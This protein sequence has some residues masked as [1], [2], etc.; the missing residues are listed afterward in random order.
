M[1]SSPSTVASSREVFRFRV[2][3]MDCASCSGKIETAVCRIPG[4][5]G[6]KVSFAASTLTVEADPALVSAG[7]IE[8][9]VSALGFQLTGVARGGVPDGS[10]AE[11]RAAGA[12]LGDVP[13]W[14]TGKARITAAAGMLVAA[15]Y[16]LSLVMPRTVPPGSS[17]PQPPSRPFRSRVGLWQR[18]LPAPRS[19]SKC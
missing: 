3:G 9:T 18:L 10:G 13:W 11:S 16:G 1:T 12:S 5:F 4:V 6:A 8:G 17:S 7:K 14:Q 19:A 2:D 15:A